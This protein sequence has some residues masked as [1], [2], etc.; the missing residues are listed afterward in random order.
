MSPVKEENIFV[1]QRGAK[2]ILGGSLAYLKEE[3]DFTNEGKKSLQST[4]LLQK[5]KELTLVHKLLEKKRLEFKKR[6]EDCYEKQNELRAKFEKFLKDNESKRQRANSKAISER[7]LKE[8]KE[9]EIENLKLQVKNEQDRNERFIKMAARYKRYE[10]FLEKVVSSLPTDY[11]DIND[12]HIH[13]LL[14]RYNTLEET[15]N[16]LMLELQQMAENIEKAQ[17]SL[18]ND[19]QVLVYNSKLGFFQKRLEKLKQET[20]NLELKIQER[21]SSNKRRHRVVSETTMAIDNLYSRV[22]VRIAKESASLEEK[23][24][25]IR[26]RISDLSC[27]SPPKNINSCVQQSRISRGSAKECPDCQLC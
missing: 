22:G 4:L 3:N 8:Q 7:K 15:K 17:T 9:I 6:M 16:D 20:T 26:D 11:F 23:L 14:A 1:T 5:K 24:R 12:P 2:P 27:N 10:K 21:D 18:R 19:D 25:S 13:D